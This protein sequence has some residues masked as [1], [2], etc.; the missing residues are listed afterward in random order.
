MH[1]M[2]YLQRLVPCSPPLL[3]FLASVLSSHRSS[4]RW[5]LPLL[6]PSPGALDFYTDESSA[7]PRP[8]PVGVACIP[9]LVTLRST[10]PGPVS[11]RRGRL[12]LPHHVHRSDPPPLHVPQQSSRIAHPPVLELTPKHVRLSL[13]VAEHALLL[14]ARRTRAQNFFGFEHTLFGSSRGKGR[15]R[16]CPLLTTASFPGRCLETGP[17]APGIRRGRPR[18]RPSPPMTL[19]GRRDL[20]TTASSSRQSGTRRKTTD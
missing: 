8:R 11:S 18:A 6:I 3:H 17:A 12:A 15:R 5:S 2:L 16:Q 13:P 7:C 14:P 19:R 10:R 9:T 4:L 20:G 1:G